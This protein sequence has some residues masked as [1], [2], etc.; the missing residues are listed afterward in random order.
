MSGAANPPP[1]R[2]FG[3]ADDAFFAA[4]GDSTDPTITARP[5]PGRI[6]FSRQSLAARWRGAGDEEAAAV[7]AL[8]P[9]SERPPI[10]SALQQSAE[11]YTTPLPLLPMIVLSIVRRSWFM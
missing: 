3:G 9:T 7:P 10:P 8:T 11:T 5:R 4:D 1:A 6:S 2:V